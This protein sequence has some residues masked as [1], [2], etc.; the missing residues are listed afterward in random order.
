MKKAI[1]ILA[2][3]GCCSKA[4]A[5]I[6]ES[7]TLRFM[8]R[9]SL[10]GNYQQGNVE[11]FALRA[12]LDFTFAPAGKWVL[13]SQNNSLY[14]E[15]YST[16]AD[17]D[18]FSRNYLYY[19]PYRKIYPFAIGYIS[20]NYRRKISNRFFTGAGF[21]YPIIKKE[22]S[23]IKMSGSMVYERSV[24]KEDQFNHDAFN[25]Y[26]SIA[27]WRATLYSGGWI[28]ILHSCGRLYYD[29]FWQPAF[30]NRENYR[31]QLDAGLDIPAWKGINFSILY[32]TTYENI[33]IQNIRQRDHI[34]SFGLSYQFKQK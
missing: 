21:T 10:T 22:K 3:A 6:N 2:V 26:R 14:Q 19:Q 17:L 9:T 20:S 29:A 23:M 31:W 11:L 15:I 30:A 5:Q 25:G 18:I 12:K 34:L 27:A 1:L 16:K 32:L 33:V 28:Y 24:F 13:K 7:D 4:V 8:V